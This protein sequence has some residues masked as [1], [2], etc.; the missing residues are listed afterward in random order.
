MLIDCW[1]YLCI[2]YFRYHCE[3]CTYAVGSVGLMENHCHLKHY[4]KKFVYK[5]L[6]AVV[7]SSNDE[8]IDSTDEH[9]LDKSELHSGQLAES[10]QQTSNKKSHKCPDCPF[11]ST[12]SAFFYRHCKTHL[13]SRPFR[14]EPCNMRFR[15][16]KSA[17]IHA[18]HVHFNL[19]DNITYA[20]VDED[21]H[22]S[23]SIPSTSQ[24]PP[25]PLLP[26]LLPTPL[27][28][29]SK[30]MSPPP[31]TPPKRKK[32]LLASM[33]E[34]I[35]EEFDE[36]PDLTTSTN[37]AF[38]PPALHELVKE[39]LA[40]AKDKVKTSDENCIEA[41]PLGAEFVCCHC[42]HTG[43]HVNI[44]EHM[45]SQHKDLPFIVRKKA[46][47]KMAL[48]IYHYSCI[49][50]KNG[51]DSLME[52]MGHW[53]KNHVTLDFKFNTTLHSSQSLGAVASEKTNVKSEAA[54]PTDLSAL[55]ARRGCTRT[56][57]T[58]D[59]DSSS[60]ISWKSPPRKKARL[61]PLAESSPA[62]TSQV[63]TSR[64][65]QELESETEGD[66]E[67]SDIDMYT[68]LSMEDTL[69]RCSSCRRTSKSREEILAHQTE[70]VRECCVAFP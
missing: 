13:V 3:Y 15:D 65:E 28:L 19:T 37:P 49:Y 2:V 40:D 27:S 64:S 8:D 14:C 31:M 57:A 18:R 63:S 42:S 60:V 70:K 4:G 33:P 16:M 7:L 62:S 38:S 35:D 41:S 56:V 67:A 53:V 52:A 1:L 12:S 5:D 43:D 46:D 59:S 10:I 51:S 48:E 58:T 68:D 11:E 34:L 66:Q 32:D 21:E 22:T 23:A 30:S 17:K 25:P 26:P 69:Y 55:P 47:G 50:C 24:C 45:R 39:E 44:G 20:P 61:E 9:K 6:E 29:S 54:D 36:L